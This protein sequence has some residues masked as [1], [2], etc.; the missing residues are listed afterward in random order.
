MPDYIITEVSFTQPTEKVEKKG[1][2]D[3]LFRKKDND[4]ARTQA[5]GVVPANEKS[6]APVELQGVIPFENFNLVLQYQEVEGLY[7]IALPAD[8]EPYESDR[9]RTKSKDGKTLLS[10]TV[11]RI[12][13]EEPITEQYIRD[14]MTSIFEGF[15]TEGGYIPYNDFISNDKY[16]SKSFKVDNETQYY[17]HVFHTT[18]FGKFRSGLIIRD[19]G[20]YNP[21]MRATLQVIVSTIQFLPRS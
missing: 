16:V 1:A 21:Q 7:R 11:W 5:Q 13:D 19:I 14:C 12:K 15:V 9:F 6:N 17:L 8:W 2:F 4:P 3:R 10:I 18:E 20:D